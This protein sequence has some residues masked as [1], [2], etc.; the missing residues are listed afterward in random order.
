VEECKGVSSKLSAEKRR[1]LRPY[2]ILILAGLGKMNHLQGV[3]EKEEDNENENKRGEE[4]R[5]VDGLSQT[6]RRNH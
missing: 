5:R 6:V 2:Q 1:S 4:E 3:S